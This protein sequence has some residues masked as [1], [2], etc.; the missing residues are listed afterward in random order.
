MMNSSYANRSMEIL[1][2]EGRLVRQ[3]KSGDAD[4][5]AQLY[6]AC[7]DRVYRYIYFR[8]ANDRVA[9]GVTIQVFFKAWE[10]LDRYQVFGSSFIAWLYSIA[11]NQVIA[12]YRTHK[13]TAVPDNTFSLTSEGHYLGEEVQDMFD[14]QAMRDGLQFLTEEEQQVLIL[15]F[16]VGL[17]IKNIARIM[18]RREGDILALQIR[19]LQTLARYL[20]EKEVI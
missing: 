1:P 20:K 19:A 8:V 6:D 14:L 4:A 17:P 12:Y 3:A 10:Q 18:V 2:E 5:F 13:R 11:R 9:E 7:V 15:K 16:I